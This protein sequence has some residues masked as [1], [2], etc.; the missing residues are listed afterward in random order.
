MSTRVQPYVQ[1][2]SAALNHA[3]EH[4]MEAE[5]TNI[6]IT[7]TSTAAPEC[8]FPSKVTSRSRYP[9]RPIVELGNGTV[10]ETVISHSEKEYCLVEASDNSVRV[11]FTFKQQRA[12]QTIEQVIL[13][14]YMR[15]FQQRATSEQY[16]IL[17]RKPLEG[18]AMSMLIVSVPNLFNAVRLD[19]KVSHANVKTHT[20]VKW[21]SP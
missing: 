1:R 3:F 18:Y 5:T 10:T 8:S 4:I 13:K 20:I 11:S 7:E 2:I 21:F 15:F 12:S 17:R 6:T 19:D 16:S 9:I 14:R